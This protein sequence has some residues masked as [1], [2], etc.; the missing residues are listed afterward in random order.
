[1]RHHNATVVAI[2]DPDLDNLRD[3][4]GIPPQAATCHVAL[5]EGYVVEGHVP[6]EAI[7]EFLVSR[8]DAVGITVPAMPAD[9]PGMGGDASTWAAL[10]VFLIGHNG[11]LTLFEF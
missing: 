5:I 6:A 2:A 8:P 10:D 7:A 9:S 3:E 4:L 11:Q 1:M